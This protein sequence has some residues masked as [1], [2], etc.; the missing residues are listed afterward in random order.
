M[1]NHRL[2]ET[3][4]IGALVIGAAIGSALQAQTIVA[5]HHKRHK[6]HRVSHAKPTSV[7]QMQAEQARMQQDQAAKSGYGYESPLKF[8]ATLL[9]RLKSNNKLKQRNRLRLRQ[10]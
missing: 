5:P 9:H 3:L 7:E 10:N 1:K 8:S 6:H 2:L 4:G